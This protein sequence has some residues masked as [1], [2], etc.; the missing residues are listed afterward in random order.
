MLTATRI[1]R[2]L[3]SR[4]AKAR[5]PLLIEATMDGLKLSLGVLALSLLA[6]QPDEK[7]TMGV[8]EPVV[9]QLPEGAPLREPDYNKMGSHTAHQGLYCEGI[10]IHALDADR[11][12]RRESELLVAYAALQKSNVANL[13]AAGLSR[14]DQH[15]LWNHW[16][17]RGRRGRGINGAFPSRED[18]LR[19]ARSK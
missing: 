9:V 4:A 12:K 2:K 18:C 5:H 10:L 7:S 16:E 6:C 15:G 11:N 8:N 19:L 1:S 14:I 17:E 13:E 3:K